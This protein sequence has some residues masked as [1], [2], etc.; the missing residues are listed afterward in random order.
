MLGLGMLGLHNLGAYGL[1]WIGFD[2]LWAIGGALFIGL[3]L[4]TV[5]SRFVL[6]LRRVH[7]EAVGLDDFLGMGLIGVSYGLALI[8]HTY[9]FLAVFTAGL[10]LRKLEREQMPK[11]P[12]Q[13][14]VVDVTGQGRKKLATHPVKAPAAMAEVV[15]GFNEQLE[16]IGELVVVVMIGA[17]LSWHN[18]PGH[19][20]WFLPFLFLVV[21]PLSVAVGLLGSDVPAHERRLM[22]WFGIRGIGSLY[23]LAYAV[24]HKLADREARLLV[25]LTVATIAVS[26]FV[27]GVS[28]TP[29]MNR[30]SR[31]ARR[32]LAI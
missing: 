30:Y 11:E 9:G 15:L 27:H 3:M 22:A 5:V 26:T 21:R 16:R 18:I 1:R 6:Y 2:V 13:H 24:V 17:M 31:L 8:C 29:L 32:N 25:G 4:G 23:Y 19:A 20:A 28:V 12:A 10:A 7:R 14:P